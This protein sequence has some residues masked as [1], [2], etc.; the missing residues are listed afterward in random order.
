MTTKTNIFEGRLAKLLA[1]SE[2]LTEHA[3]LI[4]TETAFH[5]PIQYH[6]RLMNTEH[7]G[8]EAT[9]SHQVSLNECVG[10]E[11]KIEFLKKM[12][13]LYC[14]RRIRKTYSD[15][16]CYP[17]FMERPSAAECIIRPALC[18]AH[19][20][21]GRDPEW[22]KKH[23][24]QPHVVYLALSSKYKVG[25]TRDWPT[26]WL[27]QGAAAIKVIACT[28][29]R[30]LAGLIEL[31]LAQ[32]YSDKISWQAMLKGQVLDE[33][34]LDTEVQ[35]CLS[36]LPQQLAQYGTPHS[37]II[38]LEYPVNEYP[39]KVKSIKLDKVDELEGTL[40]GIR[41]QYLIF[42]QNRVI[43]LRSHSAYHVRFYLPLET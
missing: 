27:D 19:L 36:L 37:P 32:H 5:A 1:R 42:D 39:S 14:G 4:H 3:D 20:G 9:L 22:E 21:G 16:F 17:C 10:Q 43:N 29:Y 28:P 24:L 35:H 13:C 31:E 12:T 6:L 34:N 18:Q 40:L 26:R 33:A 30:Q 23:H 41:G 25:V 15:G 38:H 11:I 2:T 8:N 7:E